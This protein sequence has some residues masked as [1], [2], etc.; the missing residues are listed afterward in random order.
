M[1]R[2]LFGR[3]QRQG[4]LQSVQAET[5]FLRDDDG[6]PFYQKLGAYLHRARA[7]S[8]DLLYNNAQIVELKLIIV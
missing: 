3:E 5:T 7:A 8:F 6:A 4:G 2:S 1:A